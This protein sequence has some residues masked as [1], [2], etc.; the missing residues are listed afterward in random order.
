MFLIKP[1]VNGKEEFRSDKELIKIVFQV[2]IF[3]F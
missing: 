2:K 1:L 3:E